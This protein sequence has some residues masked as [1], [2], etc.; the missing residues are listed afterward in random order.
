MNDVGSRKDAHLRLCADEDV[1]AR[2]GTLLDEVM[3]LHEALPELA[4]DDVD[5][6]VELLGR[7]L[8]S[9][10]VISGMTGGTDRGREVNQ[11]LAAAAGKFGLGFGVGSQRAMLVDPEAA[12]SYRVRDVAPDV[13]LFANLGAVQ[14]R[15]AGPAAVAEL[16]EAI[17]ADALCIHLNPAQELVQDDGDRDFRGS[18]DTLAALASAL[19]VPV[20]AKET[21]CG[22][23][24]GTLVRLRQAGIGVVDVA[25]AG[26]TTWTGVEALRGSSRQRAVGEQLREWGIPTAA[27]VVFARRVGLT[28]IASGGL[29]SAS[30]ALRALALGADAAGMALP[31]LRAF[32][33]DGEAGVQRMAA[34]LTESLRALMLLVGARRPSDLRQAP[35]I[36]GPGLSRWLGVPAGG[37]PAGA[38]RPTGEI[39]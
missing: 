32:D 15:A 1:E 12:A 36:L 8:Q 34:T 28:T 9:P 5:P 20:I 6:S 2:G 16:V 22:F 23:A 29:R 37:P 38:E 39:G 30:C 26:G 14:A 24:P 13:L 21:G 33:R 17:A 4:W 31:F 18:L 3:L 11:A 10:L 35:R 27:S 7:R 19:P 25:G